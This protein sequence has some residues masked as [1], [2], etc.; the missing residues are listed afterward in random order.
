MFGRVRAS[1]GAGSVLGFTGEQ[2]DSKTG[3]TLLRA[4][5]LDPRLAHRSVTA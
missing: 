5:Y 3:F 4:R 1:S 2:F